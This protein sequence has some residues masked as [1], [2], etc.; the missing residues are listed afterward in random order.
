MPRL[1]VLIE[2]STLWA[3]WLRMHG[4]P[5]ISS[6]AP[7]PFLCAA[8]FTACIRE[9]KAFCG[10]GPASRKVPMK[11]I[12][13]R[14]E[15]KG[16]CSDG[17]PAALFRGMIDQRAGILVLHDSGSVKWET[18]GKGVM[19]GLTSRAGTF[20]KQDSRPVRGFPRSLT[21]WLHG[22]LVYQNAAPYVHY[23]A[24]NKISTCSTSSLMVCLSPSS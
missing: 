7:S 4:L 12:W 10:K 1:C 3:T 22:T 6:S 23:L 8:P 11:C 15:D 16:R 18:V 9:D 5:F 24:F 14:S 21:H 20:T 2:P 13:C 17:I 19:I